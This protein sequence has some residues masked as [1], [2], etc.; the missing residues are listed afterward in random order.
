MREAW[1]A[2][3]L[4]RVVAKHPDFIG[5]NTVGG[6][7]LRSSSACW[8][9]FVD[10]YAGKEDG[11]KRQRLLLDR[12]VLI[13]SAKV[14]QS[15]SVNGKREGGSTVLLPEIPMSIPDNVKSFKR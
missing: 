14:R 9:Q 15:R 6:F 13:G 11:I 3:A 2:F 10:W 1:Y 8:T 5:F 4:D 12:D 7:A